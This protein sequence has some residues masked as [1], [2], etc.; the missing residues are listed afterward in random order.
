MRQGWIFFPLNPGRRSRR[1][2]CWIQGVPSIPS[3]LSP[4]HPGWLLVSVRG[5]ALF[6]LSLWVQLSNL[7][8]QRSTSSPAAATVGKGPDRRQ[9]QAQSKK[10]IPEVCGA[11]HSPNRKPN[12]PSSRPR[13]KAGWH[14][15]PNSAVSEASPLQ[16]QARLWWRAGRGRNDGPPFGGMSVLAR[17]KIR[18]YAVEIEIQAGG[19]LLANRTYLVNDAISHYRLPRARQVCK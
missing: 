16:C 11:S 9:Q 4:E 2:L 8:L 7:C 6:L 12:E 5:M 1:F 14:P 13:P 19:V 10:G 3:S 15:S 17:L 18:K